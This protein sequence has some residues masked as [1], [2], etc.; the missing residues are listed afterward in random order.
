MYGF[1][2]FMKK[3]LYIWL[4]SSL[5]SLTS[6]AGEGLQVR[7][8]SSPEFVLKGGVF[9]LSSKVIKPIS[10]KSIELY[11]HTNYE[12]SLKSVELNSVTLNK[13]LRFYRED[14][15]TELDK[16]YKIE[17]GNL[18]DVEDL[19]FQ[20]NFMLSSS[21]NEDARL[22]LSSSEYYAEEDQ[23]EK[24]SRIIKIYNS[25]GNSGKSLLLEPGAEVSFEF[26]TKEYDSKNI[27]IEFWAK[28]KNAQSNFLSIKN[29]IG[30][31][32]TSIS[33]SEFGYLSV[34]NLLDAEFYDELYVDQMNWN[35]FLIELNNRTGKM[36]IYL[37]DD[38]FY[39]GICGE[40]VNQE[41]LKLMFS[42]SSRDFNPQFDRL[43]IWEFGN[44]VNLALVNKNFSS[45]NADSSSTILQ[46][47][48]DSDN[49]LR[50]LIVTGRMRLEKSDAPIFSR[51]PVLNV[52]LFG[53]NYNLSWEV[54][55]LSNAEK[56][57]IQKSYNAKEF[58]DVS[59]MSVT[60]GTRIL[61]NL[62]DFDYTDN[63]IIYY[64]IKQINEDNSEVYSSNVK[65][66]RG[67]VK[68]FTMQQNYPNPFN[69]ITTVTVEV[70]QPEEFEI[71]V[72]DIVGKTVA[73][74]HKGPLSQGMHRFTFNGTDLPSGLYLCE[75]K[76]GNELEVMKMI[77]A[78]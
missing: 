73:T 57:I 71:I 64:R 19:I 43:K 34:P 10:E 35:Y 16:V 15:N 11:L 21:G 74:L 61:Y 46:N 32:L 51:A 55:E 26:S 62:T 20:I 17:S 22:F 63:Q 39:R 24:Q 76:S 30:N 27:L 9:T 49:S 8:V 59:A 42:N 23:R 1:P 6:V 31:L 3:A 2:K 14:I 5:L 72:Y 41:N 48:F 36:T 47:N 65:V 50:D 52:V 7:S 29:E 69:P 56:F 68:H 60:D 75:V 28:M 4:I 54:N 66:G 78:K 18:E 12:V 37:N 40:L 45:Y 25:S 67:Q 13:Q 44:T 58:F 33:V 70:K 38:L 53:Q 77:L